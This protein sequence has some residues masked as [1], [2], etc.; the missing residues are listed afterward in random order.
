MGQGHS[1]LAR[2]AN[3]MRVLWPPSRDSWLR[4]PQKKRAKQAEEQSQANLA[5]AMARTMQA[6]E[7]GQRKLDS[8]EARS[9]QSE[10]ESK[11]KLGA[12]EARLAGV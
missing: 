9:K 2:E 3:P 5:A 12:A 11:A 10:E 1:R 6:E 4:K 8:A 7:Q